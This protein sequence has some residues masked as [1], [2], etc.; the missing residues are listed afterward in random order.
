[1]SS[2]I[3]ESFDDL[4][5]EEVERRS[6]AHLSKWEY[7]DRDWSQ[8]LHAWKKDYVRISDSGLLLLHNPP[9]WRSEP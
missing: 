3:P 4:S 5:E 1:V 6:L 7:S 8:M 2:D 9:E